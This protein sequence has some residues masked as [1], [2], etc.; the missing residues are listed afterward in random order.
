MLLHL[1]SLRLSCTQF[2]HFRQIT[3]DKHSPDRL[4]EHV[5]QTLLSQSTAL[6]VLAPYIANH[7]R[8]LTFIY[9]YIITISQETP[10]FS[11][12]LMSILLPT[13]ILGTFGIF[14]F[15]STYH[16]HIITSKYL[17]Y[18]ILKAHTI[19]HTKCY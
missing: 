14:S 9:R 19:A 15:N 16:Y 4:F 18:R 13:K 7:F 6:H 1:V 10:S 12:P 5:L 8:C 17:L 11:L 2:L 3:F